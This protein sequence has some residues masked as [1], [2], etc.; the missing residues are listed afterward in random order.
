M[1]WFY[2]LG[3]GLVIVL[4]L[5][6]LAGV[7]TTLLMKLPRRTF[8][9]QIVLSMGIIAVLGALARL[10]FDPKTHMCGAILGAVTFTFC[11]PLQAALW[12][13]CNAFGECDTTKTW[14]IVARIAIPTAKVRSYAPAERP[15][16]Q[17]VRGSVNI[18]LATIMGPPVLQLYGRGGIQALFAAVIYATTSATGMFNLMSAV[19]GWI[20]GIKSSSPFRYPLLSPSLAEF[21]SGRW[22]APVSDALRGAIY[23]PLTKYYKLPRAVA[24]LACFFVSAIAHELVFL[25]ADCPGSRGEWFAFFMLHGVLTVVEK[26]ISGKYKAPM[27]IIRYLITAAILLTT[28]HFLFFPVTYRIQFAQRGTE[29]FT[30]LPELIRYLSSAPHESNM[31]S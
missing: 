8:P 23:R 5:Q 30:A 12:I 14:E 21:W 4:A 2:E 3:Q 31:T 26:K 28:V 27:F 17:F 22:N 6:V 15:L 19:V 25:Y 13:Q 18:T 16:T 1:L 24:V 29:T 9:I 11:I 10:V 7:S 20:F